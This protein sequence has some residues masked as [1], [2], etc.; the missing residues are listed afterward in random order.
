MKHT[1]LFTLS[2]LVLLACGQTQQKADTPIKAVEQ[3]MVQNIGTQYSQGDYC[4]PYS[5][6][7]AVSDANP[8]DILV[9][10]DFWVENYNLEGDTLKTVSGGSHPGL[11]HVAKLADGYEVNAFDAVGD[12]SSFDPTAKAIFGDRYDAFIAL[13]ADDAEKDATRG[14]A[15]AAYVKANQIPAKF[16]QDFGWEA[17]EIK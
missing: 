11:M 6:V 8:Q 15:I 5:I 1:L 14:Q 16:Y 13:Q 3:Y 9:W 4:I 2:A 17:K 7:V 10:G 12:G